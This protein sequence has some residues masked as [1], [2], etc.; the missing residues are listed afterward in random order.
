MSTIATRN[1]SGDESADAQSRAQA[2]TESS[3]DA[4]PVRSQSGTAHT[5]FASRLSRLDQVARLIGWGLPLLS[6]VAAVR[7]MLEAGDPSS[8][9][10]G[11][12]P[13]AALGAVWVLGISLLTAAA[14]SS[15]LRLIAQ[16]FA[17]A[18]RRLEEES[19][20]SLRLLAER[21]GQ[22]NERLAQL[23]GS[24]AATSPTEPASPTDWSI[25][26]ALADAR[27]ALRSGNWDDAA[28]LLRE[29]SSSAPDD[30]KLAL[31]NEE[32]ETAREGARSKQLAELDA[33]RQVNDPERVLELHQALIPLLDSEARISLEADLAPWFLRLIHNRLRAGRIQ[34]DVAVLAGRIAE[35]FGHTM[36]GASLRAALPT[37]RRSAG[38]CAR[39]GQPYAGLASACPACLAQALSP[40][41]PPVTPPVDGKNE[42][43]SQE[44][45]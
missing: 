14:V 41:R 23:P 38:L 9:V 29:Y 13:G 24:S 42:G 12:R 44:S 8:T 25:E 5:E 4:F 21:I 27:W 37:L 33:A 32:I 11:G 35:V 45:A 16:W 15:S 39:C 19:L 3:L 31:L 22:L 43:S 10:P 40:P 17:L 6:L 28:A 30:P 18:Q 20:P 26:Q 2:S 34:T 36:E 7:I 1:N